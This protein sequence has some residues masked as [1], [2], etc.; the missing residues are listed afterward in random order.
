MKLVQAGSGAPKENLSLLSPL[1]SHYTGHTALAGTPVRNRRVLLEQSLLPMCPCWRQENLYILN[2]VR[3][4]YVHNG[5]RGQRS[6]QRPHNKND[7]IMR[8]GAASAVGVR[9]HN[10]NDVIMIITGLWRY[11]AIGDMWPRVATF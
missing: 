7:V 4:P 8:T 3:C 1:W 10:E 5:G 2:A 9:R 6:R 11:M